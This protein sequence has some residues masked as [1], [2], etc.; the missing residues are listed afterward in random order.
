MP[1][2]KRLMGKLKGFLSG[3]GISKSLCEVSEKSGN[4]ILRLLQNLLLE[5]FVWA[6][7]FEKISEPA[8]FC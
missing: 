6:V 4:F 2:K 5:V 7:L 3:Q 8:Y 1:G